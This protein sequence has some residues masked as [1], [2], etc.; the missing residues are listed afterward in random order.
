MTNRAATGRLVYGE[1][2]G[3]VGAK[4]I[5]LKQAKT[6]QSATLKGLR[7]GIKYYFQIIAKAGSRQTPIQ[8]Q[9][10]TQGLP[11]RVIITD[12]QQK[13]VEGLAIAVGEQTSQTDSAGQVFFS[14]PIGPADVA[15]SHGKTK[16][17]FSL[18]VENKV[19]KDPKAIAEEQIFTFTIP[20]QKKLNIAKLLLVV[21]V[22]AVLGAVI[23]LIRRRRSNWPPP[24]GSSHS[25]VTSR[26]GHRKKHVET[27]DM[28]MPP[29]P[30]AVQPTEAAA[31]AYDPHTGH[32]IPDW[33][34]QIQ[35]DLKKSMKDKADELPKDMFETADE[36]YHYDQKLKKPPHHKQ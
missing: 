4:T 34:A 24:K 36:L 31:P 7:P 19:P 16:R 8:G 29:P 1:D 14:L 28:P 3:F 32:H 17:Q 33:Q 11:V 9:L 12:E 15:V 6:T 18:N 30:V 27:A 5:T 20:V 35:A 13:P 23:W 26:R 10:D 2:S 25:A 22:L 21:I